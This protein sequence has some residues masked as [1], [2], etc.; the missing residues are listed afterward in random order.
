[1]WTQFLK[2]N[3]EVMVAVSLLE[4]FVV[5]VAVEVVVVYV[6]GGCCG[7]EGKVDVDV[8]TCCCWCC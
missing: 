8:E 2:I 4:V 1:M 7:I 6:G 3:V 5:E